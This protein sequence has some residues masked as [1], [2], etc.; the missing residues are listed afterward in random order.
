MLFIIVLSILSYHGLSSNHK[1]EYETY[2]NPKLDKRKQERS[3][4][5]PIEK[6][7]GEKQDGY[8]FIND[9]TFTST[10]NLEASINTELIEIH[11]CKFN[12]I[13]V[14]NEEKSIIYLKT[15]MN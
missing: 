12:S 15:V 14:K 6:P 2:I 10:T 9:K 5:F 11:N 7:K 13:E 1:N 3:I 8:I 4:N